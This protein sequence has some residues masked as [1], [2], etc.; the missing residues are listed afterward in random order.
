MKSN[1]QLKYSNYGTLSHF[2]C[3]SVNNSGSLI[4]I[5]EQTKKNDY[6]NL[7]TSCLTIFSGNWNNA[8]NAGTFQ[9][10]VNNTFSLS[11]VNV[12]CHLLF[13]TIDIF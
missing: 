8:L 10:N 9:L 1:K 7:Y 11:N 12:G 3:V 5:K 2:Y 4:A 13:S 6:T